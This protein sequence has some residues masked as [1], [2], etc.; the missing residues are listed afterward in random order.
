MIPVVLAALTA[1]QVLIAAPQQALGATQVQVE[2]A[3]GPAKG[4]GTDFTPSVAVPGDKDQ[5]VTLEY[6]KALVRLYLAPPDGKSFLLSFATTVDLFPTGTGVGIGTDR[7]S[8]LREIGGPEFEDEDQ[9][10]YST[11]VPGDPG[12]GDRVRLFFKDDKVEAI[13][14][15]YSIRVTK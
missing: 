5:V 6:P 1:A 8:V 9:I 4:V 15:R 7:G 12:P 10:V 14:W 2:K 13:E 3:L 11:P